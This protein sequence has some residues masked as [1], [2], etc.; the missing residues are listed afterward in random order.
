MNRK[1]LKAHNTPLTKMKTMLISCIFAISALILIITLYCYFKPI[2]T[3][4]YEIPGS[5]Y[6]GQE[7]FRYANHDSIY[8]PSVNKK[9]VNRLYE[10]LILKIQ[11]GELL[12]EFE[13][14]I[15]QNDETDTVKK[16][17]DRVLFETEEIS[18]SQIYVAIPAYIVGSKEAGRPVQYEYEFEITSV[19]SGV[20]NNLLLSTI[21]SIDD[22]PPTL[23]KMNEILASKT[24]HKIKVRSYHGNIFTLNTLLYNVFVT[25]HY[26]INEFWKFSDLMR[27]DLANINGNSGGAATAYEVMLKKKDITNT[28]GEFVVTGAI[29][30]NGNITSVGGI[31]GKTYL[32]IKHS[33]P[34]MFVP[35]GVN[36]FDA[37]DIKKLMESK[38]NIIPIQNIGDIEAYWSI[39]K[40]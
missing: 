17:P 40:E 31:K 27:F 4:I 10:F 8:I 28:H 34:V 20:D 13:Q 32:S 37:V 24:K 33:I 18:G 9:T 11:H 19:P 3:K 22:Q 16:I 36:Y 2:E 15:L 14:T 25:A 23:I 35:K 5:L 6:D 1:T 12:Q 29:D 21:L 7:L 26:R 39:H 30:V 38:I